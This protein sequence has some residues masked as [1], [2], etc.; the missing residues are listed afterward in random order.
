MFF[1]RLLQNRMNPS[2]LEAM[3][4]SFVRLYLIGSALSGFTVVLSWMNAFGGLMYAQDD[5]KAW[6][7]DPRRPLTATSH[8]PQDE[9]SER[10]ERSEGR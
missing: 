1:V 7:Q 2:P 3:V 8:R 6:A 5:L 10:T 9:R 4:W